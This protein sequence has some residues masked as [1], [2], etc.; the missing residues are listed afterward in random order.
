MWSQCAKQIMRLTEAREGKTRTQV[1]AAVADLQRSDG[2]PIQ[3]DLVEKLPMTKGAVSQNCSRLVEE[4]LLQ[5]HDGRYRV[6]TGRLLDD[7][8]EHFEEYLRRAPQSELYEQ[9]VADTNETRTRTKRSATEYFEAD[10][11]EDILLTSLV[12]SLGKNNIQT[13]REVFLYT[14]DVLYH[15][16]YRA[17]SAETDVPAELKPILRLAACLDATPDLVEELANRHGLHAE[18]AGQSPATEIAKHAYGGA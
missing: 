8:R 4:S 2:P 7:Y 6:D 13:L 18:L 11:L 5:E 15:V 3:K 16:A 12:S 17:V 9:E 1:L 14:D 10:L